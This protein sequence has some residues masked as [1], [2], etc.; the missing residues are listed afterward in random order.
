MTCLRLA[1]KN[2]LEDADI[3]T[4]LQRHVV[5]ELYEIG[6]KMDL[7]LYQLGGKPVFVRC[8]NDD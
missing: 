8:T 2:G 3:G 1:L 5:D 7:I 4:L 6:K